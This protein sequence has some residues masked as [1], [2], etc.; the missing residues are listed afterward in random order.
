MFDRKG[1]PQSIHQAFKKVDEDGTSIPIVALDG[2]AP[3]GGNGLTDEQ[4]RATPVD[5]KDQNGTG[6]VTYI[7]DTTAVTG[8]DAKHVMCLTDTVFATFTRTGATGSIVGLEL[9]A[10]TLL[11]GPV[12]AITLTSGAVAAYE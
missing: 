12:T 7:T 8:L 1:Y 11:V 4:L 2:T 5:T 6:A 9:P 10:G 3:G